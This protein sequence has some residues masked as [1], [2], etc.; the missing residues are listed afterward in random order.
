MGLDLFGTGMK[1][2]WI[3]YKGLGGS[4][5]DQI[6]YLVTKGSAYEGDPIWNH[7]VPV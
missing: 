2:V 6:C 1:L 3:I 7:T 5:M 4:G